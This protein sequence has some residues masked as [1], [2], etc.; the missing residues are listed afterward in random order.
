MTS[1]RIIDQPDVLASVG[2]EAIT[3]QAAFTKRRLWAR[4][5]YIPKQTDLL[6]EAGLNAINQPSLMA[7]IKR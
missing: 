7:I 3:S 5:V 4:L 6:R 2:Y 1:Y